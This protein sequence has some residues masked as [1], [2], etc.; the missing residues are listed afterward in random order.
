MQDDGIGMPQ[1][2]NFSDFKSLGMNLVQ[3]LASQLGAQM[4]VKTS[5]GLGFYLTFIE[6]TKPNRADITNGKSSRA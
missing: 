3:A 2:T 6:K 4:E 5:N 1:N